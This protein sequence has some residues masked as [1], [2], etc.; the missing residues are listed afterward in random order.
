MELSRCYWS[1]VCCSAKPVMTGFVLGDCLA[2]GTGL[3]RSVCWLVSDRMETKINGEMLF[4]C[5]KC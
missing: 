1:A 3:A 4:S 2:F 5:R